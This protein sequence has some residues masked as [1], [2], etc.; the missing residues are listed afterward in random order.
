MY[1]ILNSQYIIKLDEWYNSTKE[2]LLL[3]GNSGSGKSY[4]ITKYLEYKNYQLFTYSIIET[5]NKKSLVDLLKDII[6]TPVITDIFNNIIRYSAIIIDDIDFTLIQKNDI[7]D[8]LEFKK[9]NPKYNTK[10]ILI[11]NTYYNLGVLKKYLFILNIL[12]PTNIELFKLGNSVLNDTS[13]LNDIVIKSENDYRKFNYL[14]N[15]YS[16]NI[17]IYNKKD[18][19]DDIYEYTN[20]LY[21]NY[22]P[23]KDTKYYN[24]N[25]LI[26]N[27]LYENTYNNIITNSTNSNS[28][29]INILNNIYNTYID[30]NYLKSNEKIT[31]R[32]DNYVIYYGIKNI[33]YNYN[34]LN[35]NTKINELN[36]PKNISIYNNKNLYIKNKYLFN[37]LP[38]YFNLKYINYNLLLEYLFTLKRTNNKQFNIYIN[39]F[40]IDIKILTNILDRYSIINNMKNE[41]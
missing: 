23:C 9:K 32:L 26:Y 36:Y 41:K 18:N 31:E 40:S 17:N 13:K 38:I 29:K 3:Y 4:L 37:K 10:I 28:D 16:S 25:N 1:N 19:N 8:L 6:K 24:D 20:K 22:E 35:K 21:N 33:S 15:I 34:K 12:K 30:I 11:T 5:K 27:M 14:C 39:T 7:I 2:A